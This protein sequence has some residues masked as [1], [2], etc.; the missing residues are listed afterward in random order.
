MMALAI[1]RSPA[2]AMAEPRPKECL[3][4]FLSYT[5]VKSVRMRLV[6][7]ERQ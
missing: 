1:A 2:S 3:D 5:Q 6:G 7:G 4:E